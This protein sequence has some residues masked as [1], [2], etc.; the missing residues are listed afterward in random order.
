MQWH[1]S[2]GEDSRPDG[3]NDT[4]EP[5]VGDTE[6]QIETVYDGGKWKEQAGTAE[7]V[8]FD[9]VEV[10]SFLESDWQFDVVLLFQR[11]ISST[12]K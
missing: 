6:S 1:W 7:N 2:A 10:H 12:G 5:A 9:I 11:R 8:G 3:G 4:A